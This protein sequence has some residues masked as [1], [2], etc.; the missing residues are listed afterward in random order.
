VVGLVLRPLVLK[1][2][3]A[4]RHAPLSVTQPNFTN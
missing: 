3:G 1:P 2:N 4:G